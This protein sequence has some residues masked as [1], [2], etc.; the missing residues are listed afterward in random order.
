MSW[1]KNIKVNNK[2][3]LV[4][5]ISIIFIIVVGVVGY[6]N[7]HSM[8]TESK[9]MYNNQL[10]P[11]K[12]INDIRAQS[13]ANESLLKDII[14]T[15][16]ENK[17]NEFRVLIEERLS[18]IVNSF[19]QYK[20]SNLSDFEQQQL[21]II[22]GHQKEIA[23][24][25]A[26]LLEMID[27]GATTEEAY[28]FYENNLVAPADNL[29]ESLKETADELAIQAD[30][31]IHKIESQEKTATTIMI[32]IIIIATILSITLSTIISRS[33]VNPIKEVVGAIGRAEKG[34]LTVQASY[35][36]KDEIGKMVSSFNQL[37][38]ATRQ[39]IEKVTNS[40]NELAASTEQISASTQEI[41]SGSQQQAHDASNSAAMMTEMTNVVEEVAQNAE[42]AA[43]LAENTMNSA[44]Y[45]SVVI[46]EAL[47]GMETIQESINELSNKS[48]QIGEIV[49]VIDDIAEQT[50]L[51]ALNAAIEAARAGDAGKGFAVVA[52]EVRKLAERSSKATKEISDLVNVIQ[53][54]TKASVLSVQ[55]GSE[56][57]ARV[58]TAFEEIL[59]QIAESV[60]KITEIAAASE[61]QTAQSEEVQQSMTSIAAVSQEISA[62]IE[63]TAQAAVSLAE[64]AESL[65][66]L[67]N[68]F[69]IK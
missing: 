64:M 61:Q 49:E 56:K 16:D 63:E 20:K 13:R 23:E 3:I 58:G 6:S 8:T 31:M 18:N 46:K 7:M 55:E 68:Q 25:R 38:E 17:R 30:E 15:N 27:N 47:D 5:V 40:A 9:A 41:S 24:T 62:G 52:D 22:D 69:K 60:S 35:Q 26:E 53:D 2:L 29:A 39:A 32:T 21:Q 59:E 28:T 54:N 36:S 12:W 14:L 66:Q 11:I 57:S 45:G 43:Q 48:V 51:L 10:L 44:K 19:E 34:D 4:N 67:A 37:V 50:N 42:N 65:N 33:I 1:L